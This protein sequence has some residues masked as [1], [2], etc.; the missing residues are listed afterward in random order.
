MSASL[1]QNWCGL[2]ELSSFVIFF[3]YQIECR[4]VNNLARVFLELTKG[5]FTLKPRVGLDFV[6]EPLSIRGS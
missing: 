5:I 4:H 3:R 6:R 1:D 2:S